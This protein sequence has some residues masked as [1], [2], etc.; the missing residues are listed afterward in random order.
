MKISKVHIH[1]IYSIQDA[2][3]TLADFNMMVGKNGVGKSNILNI[4]NGFFQGGAHCGLMCPGMAYANSAPQEP[5]WIEVELDLTESEFAALPDEYQAIPNKLRIRKTIANVETVLAELANEPGV[6]NVP[7][8]TSTRIYTKNGMVK[9]DYKIPCDVVFVAPTNYGQSQFMGEKAPD[10]AQLDSAATILHSSDTMVHLDIEDIKDVGAAHALIGMHEFGMSPNQSWV[11]MSSGAQHAGQISSAATK[12][13]DPNRLTL[14]LCDEPENSLHPSYLSAA[15]GTLRNFANQPNCQ[16]VVTTHSPQLVAE[17]ATDLTNIMRLDR[18]D[19]ATRVHQYP[20]I[21][22]DKIYNLTF[23]NNLDRAKM[24]FSDRVILVEG[25]TETA[26]FNYM[27]ENNLFRNEPTPEN[28]TLVNCQGKFYI[29]YFADILTQYGIPHTTLWDLD[30]GKYSTDNENI[31]GCFNDLM[32]VGYC[33]YESIEPFCGITKVQNLPAHVNFIQKYTDGTIAQNKRD[34]L[35]TLFS[36]LVHAPETPEPAVADPD[37]K[38]VQSFKR[39]PTIT[40]QPVALGL[41]RVTLRG[42][43][44]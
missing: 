20:A 14:L 34:Q 38:T 4:L 7:N 5:L 18:Y 28:V 19:G 43:T 10:Q 15:A 41:Y 1:N 2:E 22:Q 12:A 40:A 30:R 42:K 27:T 33:F 11:K 44:K 29:K 35:V 31:L 36:N 13:K 24:F 17:N 37:F 6:T 32:S 8:E 9:S 16:V 21:T 26:F 23:L 39:V 25:E 3:F